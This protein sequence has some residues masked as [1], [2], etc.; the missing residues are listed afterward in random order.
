MTS[1]TTPHSSLPPDGSGRTALVIGATGGFGGAMAQALTAKG[2]RVRALHRRPDEARQRTDLPASIDWVSGN[3]MLRN[4]VAWAASGADVIVHGANPP[5]YRNWRA[6]AIPM[7]ANTIDAARLSGARIL[8]PG[9]VYNFGPDAWPT[10]TEDS[11]QHP[12]SRKG[13]I[14]VEMEAMLAAAADRGVRTLV[15]RAG[16]YFGPHAVSSWLRTVMVRPGRPLRSVIWPGDANTGHAFAYLPDMAEAATRLLAREDD[17]AVFE[18]VNFG[19][20]WVEPGIAFADALVRA[21]GQ[22][23]A[24]I[25]RLP[26]WLMRLAAPVAPTIR[27][28]LEMRYL[29]RNPVRLDNAKLVALI[30]EEPHTPLDA[31]LRE[32]LAEMGSLSAPAPHRIG[33]VSQT[34]A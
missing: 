20:H 11:P 28:A 22:T 24:R 14:R 25:R 5:G 19:G 16:D 32:T 7:L 12:V 6:R 1:N 2:W 9:N 27:E 30:G 29:W 18:T 26:W 15:L 8:F 17:L 31:A 21:S 3:A 33:G 4:D 13:A 34:A 10:V 23:T